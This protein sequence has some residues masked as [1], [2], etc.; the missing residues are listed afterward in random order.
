MNFRISSSDFIYERTGKLRDTY[1]I[2]KKVGEGAFSSVRIIKHRVTGEKRAVKTIHKRS[3]RTDEEKAMIFSEV[4]ILSSLDHPNIIKLHEYYQDELNYYII[5]E[6]CSGG[7]LFE[8]IL[9]QGSISEATAAEYMRQIFS[10][11][12]YLHENRIAH[13]DLKPENFLLSS[14]AS[15][16]YL[17]I[18]D[19]GVSKVCSPGE[20]MNVKVGTAYYIAPEVIAK[21]YDDKC[22]V[23][24][25]GV[26]MFILLCGYP[27]FGGTNDSEILKKISAGRFTFQSPDWDSIS[28]EAKNLIENLLRMEPGAR[29]DARQALNHPWIGNACNDPIFPSSANMLFRNLRNF[30]SEQMLKK[31]AIGFIVSQLSTR[32]E[33]EEMMELFR[34]LDTDNSGTLSAEEIKAGFLRV[35]SNDAIDIDAEVDRILKEVDLNGSGVIEYSEFVS[36]TLSKIQ[37][38]SKERLETA[39]KAFDLDGS[40]SISASELKEVLGRSGKYDDEIWEK[41]IAEVDLNNDGVIDINEFTKMMLTAF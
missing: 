17:K 34:S 29:F 6:Y 15:N 40:G 27:P 14:S 21:R 24:S 11:L 25:A 4:S 8:R 35:F 33:R 10:I 16:A 28:Q 12:S 32:S 20:Y 5:T 23:W 9:S 36:A 39:F 19:F 2:S 7:E 22:D 31:A 37:L 18:I 3:L 13:R 38:L 26:I 1:K 41:I 30:R